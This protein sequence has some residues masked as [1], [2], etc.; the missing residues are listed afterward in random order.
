MQTITRL[1]NQFH[2]NNYQLTLDLERKKRT[3]SGTVVIDGTL[4]KK[5]ASITLHAKDLQIKKALIKGDDAKTS[6]GENDELSVK[7]DKELQPGN[8]KV[9]LHFTG[10]ITDSAHGVYPCYFKHDGK[11]KELLATQFES[12]HAREVFPCIDEPEAKATFNLTLKTEVGVT[13]LSNMPAIEQTE[14]ENQLVTTFDQSPK[15]STYLLAFAI[16]E[17]HCVEGKTD[18]GVGVRIFATPAQPKK[19]LRFALDTAIRTIEFFDDYFDTPYP[20]P[21]ADHIALPDMGG[22]ASAAMENWGLITYREDYLIADDAVGVSAKQR[23]ARVI[24]HETSHQWFG[25]LVTMK[26]WDDL[27]LNE[28][29]VSLMEFVGLD[30]LFPQWHHWDDFVSSETLPSLRRDSNPGVQPIRT[31]VHH[32]DEIGTLFDGAIVYA[33]GATVLRMLMEYIGEEKFR[34]GLKKYFKQHAYAN[35][36]GN[37]LWQALDPSAATFITPWLE[38]SGFPVINITKGSEGSVLRQS[39]FL[40]GAKP[41]ETKTWPLLLL[42]NN[43][44]APQLM[45]EK[46]LRIKVDTPLQLNIGGKAQYIVNYDKNSRNTLIKKVAEQK[47]DVVDRLRLLLE[48]TLLMRSSHLASAELIPLLEAYKHE[49]SQP[50]WDMIGFSLGA[51]KIFVENDE[52]A[53]K[54]LKKLAQKLALKE[55]QRLGWNKNDSEPESDTKLRATVAGLSVYSE[56]KAII[57]QALDIYIKHK[58]NIEKIDGEMRSLMLS[59]AVRH[60]IDPQQVVNHLLKLHDTTQSSELQEDIISGLTGTK[61]IAVIKQLL[62]IMTDSQRVRPQNAVHWFI[63]CL[64][65]RYGRNATWQWVQ[66]NWQWV[67]D[68]YG[69]DKSYDIFPTALG[70]VLNTSQQLKEYDSFFTPMMNDASIKRAIAIGKS[71]IAARVEW[72]QQDEE[73]VLAA[74]RNL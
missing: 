60:S 15:M 52:K 24:V 40:L 20:L 25:N 41:D 65:N 38:K 44:N 74:L 35:T 71:E 30:A 72:L 49:T 34:N 19:A 55:F 27:W 12:H 51:L 61:D 3:F 7:I 64:R 33:K 58:N 47:L 68:T 10:K 57:Q 14:V 50:V 73:A 8:Y 11:D 29:F 23:I 66:D 62:E 2:P 4:T 54:G 16:G 18:S 5:S 9:E 31:E 28:S 43:Q 13:A 36:T 37:D 53:E 59:T 39:E 69:S 22:G 63:Y 26:W 46:E 1:Y 17:V 56:D 6:L 32:P 67:E 42:A 70:S 21:K 48:T 45:Q